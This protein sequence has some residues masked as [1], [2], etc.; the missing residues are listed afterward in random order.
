MPYTNVT[1]F[2]EEYLHS[3]TSNIAGV[4]GGGEGIE[5]EA[6]EEVKKKLASLTTFR[7]AFNQFGKHHTDVQLRLARCKGHF[8]TCEVCSRA[9]DMLKNGKL[10]KLQRNVIREVKRLHLKQ[11]KG[12]RLHLD[13]HRQLCKE[14]DDKGQPKMALLF[15]DGMTIYTTNTPKLS[16]SN[17]KGSTKTIESRVIG[18]E[19]VCGDIETM[20]IYTTDDMVGGGALTMIE[21]QRQAMK[22][23]EDLLAAQGQVMPRKIVFQFDNCG[24]NK[25]SFLSF[26]FIIYYLTFFLVA[27]R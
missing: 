21:V 7:K 24:E 8:Q 19:V 12:E 23:L 2:Y 17:S 16:K 1:E 18:V 13:M 4:D 6:T 11:Q 26:L 20:F 5:F 27:F 15:S 25:V 3:F 9:T 22:D 14:K 10:H